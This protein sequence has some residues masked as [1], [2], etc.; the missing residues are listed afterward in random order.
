MVDKV[1]CREQRGTGIRANSKK[2][3]VSTRNCARADSQRRIYLWLARPVSSRSAK[4][5]GWRSPPIVI[6]VTIVTIVTTEKRTKDSMQQT[7]QGRSPD[8]PSTVHTACSKQHKYNHPSTSTTHTACSKQHKYDQTSTST[9]ADSTEKH[10]AH[11]LI[12]RK[13]QRDRHNY[14]RK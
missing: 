4:Q 1:H 2:D 7:A 14:T 11:K 3:H 9:Q 10:T 8:H 6:I 5:P 13:A 12:Y